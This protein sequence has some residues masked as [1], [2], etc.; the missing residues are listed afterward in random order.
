MPCPLSR[1]DQA[2]AELQHALYQACDL[3]LLYNRDLHQVTIWVTITGT[4]PAAIA[5]ILNASEDPTRA[6]SPQLPI[7]AGI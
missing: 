1:L 3:Q 6:D 2:P 7:G 4:T 5:G